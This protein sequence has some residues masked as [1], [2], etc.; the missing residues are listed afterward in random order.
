M[1]PIDGNKKTFNIFFFWQWDLFKIF[2]KTSKLYVEL[3]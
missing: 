3:V 1:A 2:G